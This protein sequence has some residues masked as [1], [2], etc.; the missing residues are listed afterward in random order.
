[1]VNSFFPSLRLPQVWMDAS[2]VDSVKIQTHHVN[3]CK[4]ICK[5]HHLSA[6]DFSLGFWKFFS[7]FLQAS[8]GLFSCLFCRISSGRATTRPGLSGASW[9]SP[10]RRQRVPT[11]SDDVTCMAW[12][13]SVV[14]SPTCIQWLS[15]QT[16]TSPGRSPNFERYDWSDSGILW[17]CQGEASSMSSS[18]SSSLGQ[19]KFHVK[20][21]H[22][23]KLLHWFNPHKASFHAP[24]SH[25][26]AAVWCQPAA[27]PIISFWTAATETQ[28][29]SKIS[30]VTVQW[31]AIGFLWPLASWKTFWGIARS[32]ALALADFCATWV[33]L[34]R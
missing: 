15:P 5:Y 18:P 32:S 33:T 7:F 8:K 16:Q 1:M 4:Y 3:T 29:Q 30:A 14:P 11:T 21:N 28:Q 27:T 34:L 17:T 24:R 22:Q 26:H 9:R 10:V 25:S 19:L 13:R 20:S 6:S 2:V 31:L 12:R 23:I